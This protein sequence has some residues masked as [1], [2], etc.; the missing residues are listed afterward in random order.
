MFMRFRMK[1]LIKVLKNNDSAEFNRLIASDKYLDA[2]KALEDA[3][4]VKLVRAWGGEI[5][6]TILLDHHVSYQLSRY[7]VWANRIGGFIAG[8]L[9]SVAAHYLILLIEILRAHL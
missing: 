8:V 1:K 4:C 3:G 2:L 7:E 5:T 9:T 6:R